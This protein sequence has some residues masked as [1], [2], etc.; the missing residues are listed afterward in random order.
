MVL[1]DAKSG[2]EVKRFT[3][4]ATPRCAAFAPDGKTFA[5]SDSAVIHLWELAG[6]GKW[7]KSFKGHEGNVTSLSFSRDGT[8]LASGS[9]D[10]NVVLWDV[11]TAKQIAK[12]YVYADASSGAVV[13]SPA[14]TLI[15]SAGKEDR[16]GS[17][18]LWDGATLDLRKEVRPPKETSRGCLAF[19]PDGTLLAQGGSDG[20]VLL[21][22]VA[23]A[24]PK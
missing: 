1:Y 3:S 18:R 23:I 19:S 20:R 13:F 4:N 10:W 21:W 15:A 16:F 8:K 2:A 14:G 12:R 11:A 7:L 6:R 24:T 22:D 17:F 5:T 9:M